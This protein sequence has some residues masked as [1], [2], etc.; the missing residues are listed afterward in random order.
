[1]V[2]GH[3]PRWLARFRRKANDVLVP[4]LQALSE[5]QENELLNAYVWHCSVTILLARGAG[6]SSLHNPIRV[7]ADSGPAQFLRFN[8][9]SFG[10]VASCANHLT[11]ETVKKL[12]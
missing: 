6:A 1:V 5:R 3:F 7:N 12:T 9:V 4:K 11:E 2:E 10:S 8:F